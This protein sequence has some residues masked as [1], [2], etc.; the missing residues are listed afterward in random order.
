VILGPCLT[1]LQV[2]AGEEKE[3]RIGENLSHKGLTSM[4]YKGLKKK[5]LKNKQT[6]H[7]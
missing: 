3:H 2:E 5:I 1:V 6:T 4:I 7:F